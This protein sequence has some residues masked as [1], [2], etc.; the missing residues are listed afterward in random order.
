MLVWVGWIQMGSTPEWKSSESFL[1]VTET[2]LTD[3]LC[4]RNIV[5]MQPYMLAYDYQSGKHFYEKLKLYFDAAKQVGNFGKRTVVLLPEY[6]GTWL[7]VSD[8]KASV[9]E[10]STITGAMAMMVLS[11]P[12]KFSSTFFTHQNEGDRVA[13]TIFRMK[14]QAMADA[15]ASTFKA[16]AKE[17]GVTINAGSI[18]LPA[19]N[20][21]ANAITTDFSQPLYNST[22]IFYPDGTIDEKVVKKSY[23]IT[24]ELPFVTPYPMAELPEFDLSI[25]KTVLLVCADSWYPESYE[26]IRELEPEIVLVNSYCAGNNTMRA[27]W[28]GYDG[29]KAPADVDTTDISKL[30]EGEAWKKYALPGRLKSTQT[31]Y[32]VNVFLRGTLWDL[33]TDGQPFIINHG[34]LQPIKAATKAGIWNY[35]F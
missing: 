10:A 20:V 23:P 32:G 28:R 34:E 13:A 26:R 8:E 27:L 29:G 11:N 19:P 22:F 21:K 16:L 12:I 17:F 3:T 5:A 15:Y 31:S 33:G 9:A 1:D 25:G 35:C 4:V 7:V 14:A 6:L 2:V 24:S 30:K 18:V